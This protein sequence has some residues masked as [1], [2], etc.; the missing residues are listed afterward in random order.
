MTVNKEL[1]RAIMV[2]P[3]TADP[4]VRRPIEV[5]KGVGLVGAPHDQAFLDALKLY[6]IK[7]IELD[8]FNEI[9]DI[10]HLV[11]CVPHLIWLDVGTKCNYRTGPLTIP[12]TVSHSVSDRVLLLTNPCYLFFSLH[13]TFVG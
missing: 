1:A 8:R 3:M 6:P 12:N 2:S 7:R 9:D 4:P 5:I 10:R 11:E 13:D